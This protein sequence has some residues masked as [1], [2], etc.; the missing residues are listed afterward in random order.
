M[1]TLIQTVD[2]LKMVKD[3]IY[4]PKNSR[5]GVGNLSFFSQFDHAITNTKN[6]VILHKCTCD[7]IEQTNMLNWIKQINDFHQT[8]NPNENENNFECLIIFV[9]NQKNIDVSETHISQIKNKFKFA[10]CEKI[11]DDNILSE[12]HYSLHLNGYYLFSED[13]CEMAQ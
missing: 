9:V 11:N 7:Y 6:T 10:K 12:L 3:F 8:E 5:F 13:M 1:E 4:K 2:K